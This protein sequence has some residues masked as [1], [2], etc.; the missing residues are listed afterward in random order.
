MPT[1]DFQKAIQKYPAKGVQG[2]KATL[3]PVVYADRNYIT[4]DDKCSVGN[5]VWD[6]PTNPVPANYAGSGVLK[7][8]S[9]G[10]GQP[11]GF[12]ERNL[13]YFDFNLKDGG[14]LVLPKAA[15]LNIAC[16]GDFYAVAATV[17]TKGQKVFAVLA[18][19]S[20]KTGAAG[21]TI[22]GAVETSWVVTEGG[23][24]GELI[25]ISNWS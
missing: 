11:V 3:N 19:G 1:A 16:R 5:F 15:N 7:A 24:I 21:A 10:T 4:G 18:D 9:T 13:S 20:L 25:T 2:D 6:D 12:V 14:T 8:L 23:A 22:S 17:A